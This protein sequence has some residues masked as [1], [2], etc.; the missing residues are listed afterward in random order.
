MIDVVGSPFAPKAIENNSLPTNTI[1]KNKG[2][3]NIGNNAP[4]ADALAIIAEINVDED[5]TDK[6]AE[7]KEIINNGAFISN[8]ESIVSRNKNIVNEFKPSDTIV[9]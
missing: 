2:K 1:G 5:D 6:L 7:I 9:L 3:A 8:L 4:F